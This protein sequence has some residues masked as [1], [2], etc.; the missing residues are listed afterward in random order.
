MEKLLKC[1]NPTEVMNKGKKLGIDVMISKRKDK[2]YA[3]IEPTT[4]KRINFG[5]LG[6]EDA[7]F[8]KDPIRIAKFK[9]RNAKW[10]NAPKYT[11]AY[12]S[13]YLLW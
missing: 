3:I 13:Y 4:H 1:S 2:K 6:Y 9:K 10:A 7:T 5:Q 8:H 11:P 12:L